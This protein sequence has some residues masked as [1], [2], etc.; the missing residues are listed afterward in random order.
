MPG[1]VR[2]E[3]LVGSDCITQFFQNDNAVVKEEKKY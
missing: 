1:A 2:A 3:F